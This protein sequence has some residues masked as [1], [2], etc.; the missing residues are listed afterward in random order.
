MYLP[1]TVEK[2]IPELSRRF[3]V[4][5]LSGMRQVGKSTTLSHLKELG[6]GYVTLENLDDLA[7]AWNSPKAFFRSMSFLLLSMR[8]SA[9][10]ICS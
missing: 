1:R 4:V 2:I 10:R 3:K 5:M 6:R 8:S 9:P 7:L